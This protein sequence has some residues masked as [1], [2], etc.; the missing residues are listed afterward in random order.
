MKGSL[1]DL[2]VALTLD[3]S[4]RDRLRAD[5][6]AVFADYEL[7][8]HQREVLLRGDEEILG[9]MAEAVGARVEPPPRPAPPPPEAPPT[10]LPEGRLRVTLQPQSVG[11]QWVWAASIAPYLEAEPVPEGAFSFLLRFVPSPVQRPD[12]TEA[13]RCTASVTPLGLPP[14]PV[15][16]GSPWGHRTDT[17]EVRDAAEAVR[18]APADQRYER[19]LDLV[20]AVTKEMR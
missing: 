19:I 5:P 20:A 3:P 11:D 14:E 6:D 16:L 10:V 12:G 4:L 18:A 2:M 8:A 9:L 15:E 17:P 1:R 13:V 7:T